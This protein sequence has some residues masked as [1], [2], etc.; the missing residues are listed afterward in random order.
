M[1]RERQETVIDGHRYEMT[2]LGATASYRLFHKLFNI[3]GPSFGSVMDA[4]QKGTDILDVDL[5]SNVVV[6]GIQSLTQN[7]KESDLDHVIDVLKKQTHVSVD[8]AVHEKTIPLANVF[9]AHFSGTLASMFKWLYWGLTV[10]YQ[11]FSTAFANLT[12]PSVG[13]ESRAASSPSQ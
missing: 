2:M 8:P 6:Q 5:S 1:A 4:T 10:Q 3:I 13:G 12:L 7:L 9:E 11:D